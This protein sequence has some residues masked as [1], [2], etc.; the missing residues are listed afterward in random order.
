MRSVRLLGLLLV[1]AV[2]STNVNAQDISDEDLSS[3]ALVMFKIDSLKGDMKIRTNDLVK[4]H[5]LM[6]NGRKFNAIKGAKGD[7]LKLVELA[8][9]PEELVAYDSIQINIDEMKVKFKEDYTIVIKSNISI[10][11]FNQ[12][13]KSLKTDEAVKQRYHAIVEEMSVE[14]VQG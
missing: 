3:Y 4:T 7:S 11:A 6:E 9:T 14:E 1:L 2:V 5:P 8:V 13:K 12:I 10:S